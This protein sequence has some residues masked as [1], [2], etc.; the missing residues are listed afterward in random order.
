[1]EFHAALGWSP[2]QVSTAYRS[3]QLDWNECSIE[4]DQKMESKSLFFLTFNHHHLF[5]QH[6]QFSHVFICSFLFITLCLQHF[7]NTTLPYV[8]NLCVYFMSIYSCHISSL[9]LFIA[10]PHLKFFH[11]SHL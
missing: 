2:L 4:R 11:I 7:F 9:L 8:H 10:Y 3:L 6:Q 5:H 1:M